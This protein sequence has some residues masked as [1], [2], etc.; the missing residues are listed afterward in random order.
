MPQLPVVA[1]PHEPDQRRHWEHRPDS[2]VLS[3]PVGAPQPR[4]EHALRI[5]QQPINNRR[6]RE[7]FTTSCPALGSRL[8]RA[9]AP[10]GRRRDEPGVQE[11]QQRDDEGQ[12][13]ARRRALHSH[14]LVI[15]SCVARG[16]LG[17]SRA[18]AFLPSVRLPA[19]ARTLPEPATPLPPP[20]TRH[21]SRAGQ[22]S[23]ARRG[24]LS[25]RGGRWGRASDGSMHESE[26]AMATPRRAAR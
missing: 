8:A 1:H 6:R 25:P 2:Q 12:A 10:G 16:R 5:L 15:A 7:E 4:G 14:V 9:P 24:A 22:H 17:G 18:R 23:A 26:P 19:H 3:A 11:C 20:N 21:P 13:E